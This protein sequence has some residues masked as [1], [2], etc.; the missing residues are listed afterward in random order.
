MAYESGFG[1]SDEVW[2]VVRGLELCGKKVFG[3]N[4]KATGEGGVVEAFVIV[5]SAGGHV[6]MLVGGCVELRNGVTER[7]VCECLDWFVAEVCCDSLPSSPI[8]FL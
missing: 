1:Y 8:R 5:Y 3:Q 4:R 2:F 6:V 7:V